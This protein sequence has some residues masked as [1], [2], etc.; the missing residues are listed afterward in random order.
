MAREAYDREAVG[1]PLLQAMDKFEG[2][3][4]MRKCMS[5]LMTTFVAT[6]GAQAVEFDFE[7]G[8]QGWTASTESV[9]VTGFGASGGILGF[10][11]ITPTGPFD[12]MVISPAVTVD[13]AAEHWLA[14]EMNFTN[15]TGAGATTL[16]IFYENEFGGFSEPRS[17][18]FAISPNLGWQTLVFDMA[19]V[20][21]GRD[22]WE[23]TVTRFRLDPG[24][25]DPAT[26]V[27]Y[28]CDFDRIALTD[29]TDRDGIVDDIEIFY[30]GDI[31]VAD[32]TTDADGNGILDVVEITLGL[33]PTVD[34]GEAVPAAT[35]WGLAGLA[36]IAGAIA[37]RRVRH[38]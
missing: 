29:D 30:W 28:R 5:I 33:D 4:K 13:A 2:G 6:L 20:Q 21:G 36:L 34:E 37:L 11:Y 26:F 15:E 25:G 31:G 17:R 27:G 12:P 18:T 9:G 7:S 32:A 23:G 22:P 8:D 10:E 38:T 19:P 24:S 14:L 16:Q 1:V 3:V 35:A